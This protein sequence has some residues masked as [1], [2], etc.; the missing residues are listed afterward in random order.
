MGFALLYPSY[1]LP[2]LPGYAINP[3]D[4]L[5]GRQIQTLFVT[6]AGPIFIALGKQQIAQ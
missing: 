6:L 1:R 4:N 3:A 5:A 2:G